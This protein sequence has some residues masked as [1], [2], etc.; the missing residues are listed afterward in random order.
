MLHVPSS[1]HSLFAVWGSSE[2]KAFGEPLGGTGERQAWTS[3]RRCYSAPFARF[4]LGCR[5]QGP[6]FRGYG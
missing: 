1:L 2:L 4:W 3:G 6:T 5:V